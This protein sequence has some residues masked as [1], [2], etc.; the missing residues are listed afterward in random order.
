MVYVEITICAIG[1][2]SLFFLLIIHIKNTRLALLHDETVKIK[3][4]SI[5]FAS[6]FLLSI[7]IVYS[8]YGLFND[9]YVFVFHADNR[10]YCYINLY[11]IISLYGIFKSISYLALCLRMKQSFDGIFASYPKIFYKAWI[12]FIVLYVS[13][14]IILCFIVV[15]IDFINNRC[16]YDMPLYF[17]GL[18]VFG[19]SIIC[20]VTLYL[21]LKPLCKLSKKV[22]FTKSDVDNI[23]NDHHKDAAESLKTVIHK[24]A[25]LASIS[26][27]STIMTYILL[28]IFDGG[29]GITWQ[30]IDCI[31]TSYCIVLLLKHNHGIFQRCCC[32]FG[33]LQMIHIKNP[34][35]ETEQ[36]E[37][38]TNATTGA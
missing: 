29:W 37:Q 8:I 30:V 28:G 9:L 26:L 14:V 2:V 6:F 38:S 13:L 22:T 4:V 24:N 5:L 36:T 34:P 15:G 32:C 7:G 17:V 11:L 10:T 3:P 20:S 27:I 25:I 35:S 31:I 12:V 19:D 33:H 16:Q 18:L 1:I 23:N 21:F